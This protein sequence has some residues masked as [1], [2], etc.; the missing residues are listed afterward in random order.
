MNRRPSFGDHNHHPDPDRESDRQPD[1]HAPAGVDGPTTAP[2]PLVRLSG[3]GDLITAVG[4]MLGYTPPAPSLVL[5]GVAD[6]RVAMVARTDLPDPATL[7]GDGLASAWGMFI[8]PLAN[9]DAEA[10]A[11]IAYTDPSWDLLLRGFAEAA[12]VPVLDLLRVADGRW[13][14]LDCPHPDRC[15]HLSC[16]PEGAPLVDNPTVTAP[17][18]AAGSAAPGSRDDLA[19]SL[20]PGP[21]KV[22]EQVTARLRVQPALSREQL[23]QAVCEAHDARAGGPDPV[24]PGQAAVLLTAL[25]DVHVRDACLPWADDAAWWTWHDLIRVAPPGYVAP[26]ATAIA[27]VA[28]QRGDGVMAA[29]ATDHALADTPG[30][31]LARLLKVG[32]HRAI[33]P[34]ALTT[35]LAESAAVNPLTARRRTDPAHPGGVSGADGTDPHQP[36]DPDHHE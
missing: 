19:A 3:G 31:G 22:I 20:R 12:P 34:E 4:Y 25:T 36:T 26:V 8:R 16:T 15:T 32:L 18:V 24:P 21:G 11:V 14:S 13:W 5:V 28:Y 30:Y 6:G 2:V 23:Y 35:L 33:P 29:I 10:V 9:A 17:L 27:V 1:G 7:P